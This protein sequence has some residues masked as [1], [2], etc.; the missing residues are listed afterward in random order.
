MCRSTGQEKETDGKKEKKWSMKNQNKIKLQI[1]FFIQTPCYSK[2]FDFQPDSPL[3]FSK[4]C[5]LWFVCMVH[6][7]WHFSLITHLRENGN[8]INRFIPT[9]QRCENSW[10]WIWTPFFLNIVVLHKKNIYCGEASNLNHGGAGADIM[11]HGLFL[12]RCLC[13]PRFNCTVQNCCI[14]VQMAKI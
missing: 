10:Q 11:I 9:L 2:L 14:K 4:P 7:S 6:T 5:H 12:S 3:C 13:L 1:V 8:N